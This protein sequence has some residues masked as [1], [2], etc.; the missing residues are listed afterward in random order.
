MAVWKAIKRHAESVV[1][2][3]AENATQALVLATIR[4][5]APVSR[6]EIARNSELAPPTV[7]QVVGTL[8]GRG[9]VE[10]VGRRSSRRG[11]P[12][13]ELRIRAKAAFTIGLALEHGSIT[14]VLADLDG[15][16][17]AEHSE[18]LL[19]LEPENV[20]QR[21]TS[22]SRFMMAHESISRNHLL[23]VGLASFGPLDIEAGTV[24]ATPFSRHWDRV[25][26]RR[27]L[28]DALGLPVFL[29]NNATAAAIGEFWYGA[30]QSYRDF[31]LIFIGMGVGGGLFLNGR[32][33]RGVSFNAGE[34]GHSIVYAAPGDSP[35][36]LTVKTLE[37][38]I[39]LHALKRDLGNHVDG[40][41]SA[42][43]QDRGPELS[44]W[45]V[46]AA[47]SLA[48]IVATLDSLLD[49]EAIVIG[50]LLPEDIIRHLTDHTAAF[51][52]AMVQH[53]RPHHAVLLPGQTGPL[54][55]ALGA[56]M[57]PVY[58]AF[59]IAPSVGPSLAGLFSSP[60][61]KGGDSLR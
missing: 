34:V 18:E 28:A 13:I 11:Q 5:L 17:L 52:D 36:S 14:A 20:L 2:P 39:S 41:L 7:S 44:A 46:N 53:G 26:L 31:F 56:A 60:P 4:R 57:L 12:A 47:R 27:M 25:P 51:R 8:I 54:K 35:D 30:A 6:A 32:V 40:D 29:D 16:P 21:L 45:L 43:L 55:A 50:G 9:L 48:Q 24:N 58:D 19:E 23:G 49:L 15:T 22:A 61:S 37:S 38:V 1:K 3:Q 10:E 33:H 59:L 42:L